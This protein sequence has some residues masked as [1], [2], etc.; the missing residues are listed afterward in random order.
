MEFCRGDIYGRFLE[1][2]QARR[3]LLLAFEALL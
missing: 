3:E 2:A 1:R